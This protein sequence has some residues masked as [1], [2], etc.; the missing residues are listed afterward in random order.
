M[1]NRPS[2]YASVV[3]QPNPGSGKKALWHRVG[4]RRFSGRADMV[5][6]LRSRHVTGF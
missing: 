5:F 3:V 2:H 6:A 4:R 1:S